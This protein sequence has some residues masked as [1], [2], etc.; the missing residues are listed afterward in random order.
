MEIVNLEIR[1]EAHG[2]WFGFE[3]R[4]WIGF[5]FQ[6]WFR[7]HLAVA[8]V[9]HAP[10][11]VLLLVKG[12]TKYI[13]VL[14]EEDQKENINGLYNYINNMFKYKR[15]KKM[16]KYLKISQ[17]DISFRKKKT[18]FRVDTTMM[19]DDLMIMLLFG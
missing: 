6:I 7:Y 5:V 3:I 19:D 10:E 11:H 8:H 13:V 16:F 4:I 1:P 9:L 15:C 17:K 18:H 2:H 14:K 12:P